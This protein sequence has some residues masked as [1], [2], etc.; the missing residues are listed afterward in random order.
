MSKPNSKQQRQ[1]AC[2]FVTCLRILIFVLTARNRINIPEILS[3]RPPYSLWNLMLASF[4]ATRRAVFKTIARCFGI[5]VVK[6]NRS[7]LQERKGRTQVATGSPSL[8][9][10]PWTTL[11]CLANRENSSLLYT[12]IWVKNC[13]SKKGI[14]PC[15]GGLKRSQNTKKH[16]KTLKVSFKTIFNLH[17]A[18]LVSKEYFPIQRLI[19]FLLYE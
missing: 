17:F 7:C 11:S 3:V 4:C 9:W 15:L 10:E 18:N 16:K 5:E 2:G 13:R 6:V 1:Y 8:L 19:I 14:K 12:V